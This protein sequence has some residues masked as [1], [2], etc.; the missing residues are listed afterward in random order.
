MSGIKD[1]GAAFP[2]VEY[3]GAET[4]NGWQDKPYEGMTLRDYF[5]NNQMPIYFGALAKRVDRVK[6][7][8]YTT[9][10]LNCYR[11]ADAMIKA[12]EAK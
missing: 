6:P 4:P 1:G 7:E 9:A 2:G 10:G 5:A 8:E 3:M 12:R 11:D